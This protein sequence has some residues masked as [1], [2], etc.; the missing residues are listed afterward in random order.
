MVFQ[1]SPYNRFGIY[2]KCFTDFRSCLIDMKDAVNEI[3]Q[4]DRL[5]QFD[6]WYYEQR[7]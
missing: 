3:E 2:H 7:Q 4:Q 5:E 6:I 1:H